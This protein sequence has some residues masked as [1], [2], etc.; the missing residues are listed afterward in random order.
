M[1]RPNKHR[2][3]ESGSDMQA[4]P[5]EPHDMRAP[6]AKPMGAPPVPGPPQRLEAMP[7]VSLVPRPTE[8]P[9]P[10]S[11]PMVRCA[12]CKCE[13]VRHN[14]TANGYKYYRCLRCCDMDTGA[15]S[16]FKVAIT[17]PLAPK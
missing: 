9:A 2:R 11:A 12:F 14:G 15:S 5:P 7:P 16:T 13:R 6:P 8:I 1:S 17:D 4:V 3:R 10:Q